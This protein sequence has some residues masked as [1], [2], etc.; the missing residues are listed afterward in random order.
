VDERRTV[1]AWGSVLVDE[2]RTVT[3]WG[4]VLV[5]ERRTV[6]AWGSVLVDE[7]RTVTAWGSVLVD[8]S[9]KENVSCCGKAGS[10]ASGDTWRKARTALSMTSTHCVKKVSRLIIKRGWRNTGAAMWT[11]RQNIVRIAQFMSWK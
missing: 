5:D 6:T 2:R 10:P 8:G 7:R 1:T 11:N 3:A 9:T 4:S